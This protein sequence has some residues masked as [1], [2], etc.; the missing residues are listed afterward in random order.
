M[1]QAPQ[2][3][4]APNTTQSVTRHVFPPLPHP[5][6]AKLASRKI[7]KPVTP[8]AASNVG[9]PAASKVDPTA[10]SRV[11][12]PAVTKVDPPAASK[13]A[14]PA[15]SKADLPAAPKVDPKS[16]VHEPAGAPPADPAATTPVGPFND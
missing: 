12:A 8:P 7:E 6:P 3:P 1:P 9:A 2:P 11:G 15:V 10:T 5:R 13:V 4:A 14:A 16:A